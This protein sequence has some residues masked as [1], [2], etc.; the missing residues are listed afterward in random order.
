MLFH[1]PAAVGA[2]AG[3][4]EKRM[5]R[6]NIITSLCAVLL[7]AGMASC[8]HVD[9]TMPQDRAI[10]FQVVR[11]MPATRAGES[12]YKDAYSGVPFGAYA[13]YKGVTDA[14]DSDFMTNQKVSYDGVYWA[15]VGTTYYWPGSGALDFI[16]YSPY[17]ENDGPA[18]SE[19]AISWNEWSIKDN[20]DVDL[21][22]STKAI[23]LT[24][25]VKT[26]YYNGVPTVFHHALSQIAVKLRLAYDE[27]EA[28][29]GDKTRWSVTVHDLTLSN[30]ATTGSVTF[31]LADDGEN[32][33]MPEGNT[34]TSLKERVNFGFDCT[35]LP[36]TLS[37]GTTY[38]VGEPLTVLPQP[39][40][41]GGIAASLDV[42]ITTERDRGDGYKPFIK[43]EHI[44]IDFPLGTEQL[45]VWGINQRIR[46]TIILTPC[47]SEDNGEEVVPSEISFDPTV[48]DW[49][50]ID[51]DLNIKI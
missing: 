9:L 4:K 25:P 16:C 32:W 27:V 41:T 3:Y 42:T 39:V 18:V 26:A 33:K 46:Y 36:E 22:Y 20:Y 40:K 29:T 13:W 47:K 21:M 6:I 8:S 28:D 11:S 1:S 44:N 37:A 15:P 48:E 38:A 43:E 51:L 19:D 5:K 35:D 2:A 12:D 34:W 45:P 14:T 50:D 30:V 31:S 23:G 17:S 10:S 24:G 7:V 49:D